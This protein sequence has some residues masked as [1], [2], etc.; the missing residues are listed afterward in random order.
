[1]KKTCPECGFQAIEET[2]VCPN[3]GFQWNQAKENELEPTSD[4]S[5][6]PEE[7]QNKND[8]IRWSD[9]KNVPIGKMEEHLGDRPSS[10]EETIDLAQQEALPDEQKVALES[11]SKKEPETAE[12]S[13]SKEDQA[14]SASEEASE[15]DALSTEEQHDADIL[16]AY[17]RQHKLDEEAKAAA[18]LEA[19]EAAV[20]LSSAEAES[21]VQASEESLPASEEEAVMEPVIEEA[22]KQPEPVIDPIPEPITA[23][24]EAPK[25]ATTE[26]K[27]PVSTEKKKRPRKA[28]YITAA[29]LLVAAGGGWAYYYQQ[30][31]Q[32][33]ARETQLAQENR[34]LDQIENELNDFYTNDERVFIKND[35]T[36]EQLTAVTNQLAEFQDH[37]RYDALSQEAATI[38]DKLATLTE[39]NSYFSSPAVVEDQLEEVSLKEAAAVTMAKRENGDAF[40]ELINQA[41]DMGQKEFSAIEEVQNAVKS[42]VALSGDG[43]A[44]ASVTRENY[45]A[46]MKKVQALP[47][48]SLV[49][50]LTTELRKVDTALTKR[51][52]ATQQAA[53]QQQAA[54][55]AAQ[56]AA[57]EN[58]ASASSSGSTSAATPAQS[59]SEEEYVLSPNTP[60]NTNNQ[61]IIPARQSD[62]NDVNN[63]AWVWADGV[64]EKIIA[65]AIARGYVVEGGY[66]FERVRIVN[67]EGYYNFYATNAQGSLLKGTDD[68]AFPLYLFTVNAKTGYFRGNGNDH[69]VR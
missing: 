64:K 29:C 61:P 50:S 45:N 18:A 52:T 3:C 47:I 16:A 1:M 68:S 20:D 7:P 28:L 19:E 10:N 36:S 60:T 6:T 8:D 2:P 32:E 23:A 59:T 54:Q 56:A 27:T 41:I 11:E 67:G 37:E 14:T 25:K 55:E 30:Q 66:T 51:E 15:T 22:G 17:I 21:Q 4:S 9:F 12:N 39:I 35:K 34:T 26:E 63:S 69:T 62:L 13:G 46:L 57:S 44:P 48:D 33:T 38:A 24:D 40:D 31:Q 5:V 49:E 43:E 53:A 42:M 58:N 65:T